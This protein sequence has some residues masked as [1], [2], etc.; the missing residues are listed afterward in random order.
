MT[1]LPCCRWASSPLLL[2]TSAGSIV[3]A[4]RNTSL[5]AVVSKRA[6][7]T[8]SLLLLLLSIRVTPSV[9]VMAPFHIPVPIPI[10]VP[11]VVLG[12]RRVPSRLLAALISAAI[13]PIP[14]HRR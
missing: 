5:T 6:N 12:P 2:L 9:A 11:I 14:T 1:V 8:T 7:L 4:S 13:V 3:P 10:P